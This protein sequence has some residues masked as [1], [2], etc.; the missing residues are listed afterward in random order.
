MSWRGPWNQRIRDVV[1]MLFCIV[2]RLGLVFTHT[3]IYRYIHV[4]IR[5]RIHRDIC[6][7]K[8]L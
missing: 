8:D 6:I 4:H 3:H 5:V 1:N 2:L 7:Y